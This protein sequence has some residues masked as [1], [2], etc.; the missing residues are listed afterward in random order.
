MAFRNCWWK[1]GNQGWEDSW[2]KLNNYSFTQS[3]PDF[4][5]PELQAYAKSHGMKLMMHHETSSSVINYERQL[6]DAYMFMADN[7]YD[8]VKSGYV[9]KIFPNGGHHYDQW[10][11]EHYLHCIKGR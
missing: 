8:V 2:Q 3:Y 10:M 5:V 6:D 4:N 11:N 1:V 7:G 9:G